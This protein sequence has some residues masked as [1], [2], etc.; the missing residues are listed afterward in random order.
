[1][2]TMRIGV[3]GGTFDPIHLGHLHIAYR[4]ER[5]FG[6]SHVHFVVAAAPPHK[7]VEKVIPFN[8]RYAMVALATAGFPS[9]LPSVT[10]LEP[11]ASSFS[12]HTLGKLAHP[13]R[14]PRPQL[15]FIAGEDSLQDV[16]SWRASR[17]LLNSYNFVFVTRPG[18]RTGPAESLLPQRTVARLCDLRGVRP[19]DLRRKIEKEQESNG[20][21]VYLI[22]VGALDISS[23]QIRGRVVSGKRITHLVPAPIHEYIQKLHIY[24]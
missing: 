13:R 4:A 23:T 14:G 2:G 19:R 9:F 24:G 1:L 15:Y 21:R 18:V 5:L 8:H 10:E 7:A 16:A 17:E 22:D 6:L 11:P 3:L 12:I 20:N